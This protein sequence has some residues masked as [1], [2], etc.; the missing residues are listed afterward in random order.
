M[1]G[2]IEYEQKIETKIFNLINKNNLLKGFYSFISDKT[3]STR[4][5]YLGYVNSFIEYANKNPNM[6]TIDDF[7]GYM[8]AIQKTNSGERTTSSYRIAVY[9]AL[10]KYGK[11]LVASGQL[12]SNPMDFIDRPKAVENQSTI[13]KRD[14]GF[15]SKKEIPRYINTINKGVGS[16]RSVKRQQEWKERDLAIAMIFLNT[17]I[18]CSALMKI[19]V[20]SIDFAKQTLVVT[21]KEEKVHIYDLSVELLNVIKN[22]IIKREKILNGQHTDA[23]FISNRKVRMDQASIYR[24]VNKYSSNI[25]GKHITPHKLR[26]TYGTQLYNETGDIYFVQ[27]CMGHSN[28]KTTEIYIRDTKNTTKK[29]SDIMKNLTCKM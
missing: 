19:D 25:K 2:N 12:T 23:L 6:F 20:N 15:L 17:G 4:Y 10:K 7:T 11:Y 28:P 9:S 16:E 27:E 8:L 26:A 18:R 29:A 1:K 3:M 22:W 14:V 13:A 24:V 5:T 21:D